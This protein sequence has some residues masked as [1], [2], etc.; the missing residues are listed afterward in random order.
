MVRKGNEM[1]YKKLMEGL[2]KIPQQYYDYGKGDFIDETKNH[3]MESV[4]KAL[5]Q[6]NSN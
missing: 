6:Y 5:K 1:Y 2:K 4:I 3:S